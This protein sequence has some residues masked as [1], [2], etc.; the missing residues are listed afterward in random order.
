MK[1]SLLYRAA[2]RLLVLLPT[3]EQNWKQPARGTLS[4][5]SSKMVSDPPK[6]WVYFRFPVSSS[7]DKPPICCFSSVRRR[8]GPTVPTRVTPVCH[9]ASKPATNHG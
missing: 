6:W 1:T 2:R 7:T 4:G 3:I 8:G 9:I 5:S